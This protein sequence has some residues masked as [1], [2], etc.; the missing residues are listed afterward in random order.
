MGR[1]GAA[2]MGEVMLNNDVITNLSLSRKSKQ[3][4]LKYFRLMLLIVY[5]INVELYIRINV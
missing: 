2:S 5:Q 3:Y 4:H 1:P